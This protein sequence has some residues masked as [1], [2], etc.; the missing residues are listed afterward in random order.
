LPE[1][2]ALFAQ[3]DEAGFAANCPHGRPVYK[4]LSLGEIGK[5]FKR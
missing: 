3:M 5:M 2:T 1:I 4:L